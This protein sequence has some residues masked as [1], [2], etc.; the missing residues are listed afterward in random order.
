MI[1]TCPNCATAFFVDDHLIGVDGREVKCD[2]CG[3]VWTA[4][5]HAPFPVPETIHSDPVEVTHDPADPTAT[6]VVP[7]PAADTSMFAPQ[8]AAQPP[9]RAPSSWRR[10]MIALL[11]PAVLIVGLI[12]FQGM[13]VK[14]WPAAD[15]VYQ[16]LGLG[17]MATPQ[18]P[19]H[20]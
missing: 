17:A 2:E 13:I 7:E 16:A 5:G 1:L 20:G 10:L 19:A 9:Q 12:A 3:E 18:P 4:N 15:G 6:T 8:R 14:A 11:V